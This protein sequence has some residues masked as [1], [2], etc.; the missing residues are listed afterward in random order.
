MQ[1]SEV[2]STIDEVLYC[3]VQYCTK[4]EYV[5]FIYAGDRIVV[6]STS[7]EDVDGRAVR[8]SV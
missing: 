1:Q 7:K 4:Y 5:Y 8:S 6:R 3:T 2:R